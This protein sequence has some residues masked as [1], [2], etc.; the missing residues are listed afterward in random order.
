ML[1]SLLRA[2]GKLQEAEPL[3]RRAM[4]IRRKVLGE[5]DPEVATGMKILAVGDAPCG[6]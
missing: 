6:T 3:F 4:E 1:Q 5:G 2:E